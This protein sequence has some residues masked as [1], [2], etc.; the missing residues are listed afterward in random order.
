MMLF[1]IFLGPINKRFQKIEL[2][3]MFMSIF[4]NTKK[5]SILGSHLVKGQSDF[6]ESSYSWCLWIPSTGRKYS[7]ILPS[8]PDRKNDS[9]STYSRPRDQ[10]LTA[11]W[12]PIKDTTHEITSYITALSYSGCPQLVPRDG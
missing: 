5:S 7:R 10:H 8:C 9:D 2:Y 6:Q 1:L 3:L 11:S 12:G 4:I